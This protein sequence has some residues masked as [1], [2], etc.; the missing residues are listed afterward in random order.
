MP[1]SWR[2]MPRRKGSLALTHKLFI[3]LEGWRNDRE[4]PDISGNFN[5]C[6]EYITV[7][8]SRILY[9]IEAHVKL[10]INNLYKCSRLFFGARESILVIGEPGQIAIQI[11]LAEHKRKGGL[12]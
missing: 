4:N 5:C 9:M 2:R 7:D 6:P 1:L 11:E 10:P 3:T 12:L 8:V